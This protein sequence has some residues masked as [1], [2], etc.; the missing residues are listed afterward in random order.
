MGLDIACDVFDAG[1]ELETLEFPCHLAKH[2]DVRI[3]LALKR[4]LVERQALWPVELRGEVEAP[5]VETRVV[6]E[7]Q[8]SFPERGV[9]FAHQLVV[10]GAPHVVD[11]SGQRDR[12]AVEG[13]DAE[14]G[15]QHVGVALAVEV[16]DVRLVGSGVEVE[17][18]LADKA[19]AVEIDR[20]A[21]FAV[22]ANLEALGD[23]K[24]AVP[25]LFACYPLVQHNAA[26]RCQDAEI[27][28]DKVGRAETASYGAAQDPVAPD[29]PTEMQTRSQR[30][31]AEIAAG[32]V[33]KHHLLPL[34][35]RDAVVVAQPQRG[36]E[37]VAVEECELA[38]E[39]G[40]DFAIVE[41]VAVAE[42][43]LRDGAEIGII[44]KPLVDIT[45]AERNAVVDGVSA[46]DF[47]IDQQ[48]DIEVFLLAPI[49]RHTVVCILPEPGGRHLRAKRGGV[50]KAESVLGE[51][52]QTVGGAAEAVDAVAAAHFFFE[53]HI[54]TEA[55]LVD[56]VEQRLRVE[57]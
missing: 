47:G 52:M 39:T 35:G 21:G 2:I 43:V 42:P 28:S 55:I 22:V 16:V 8:Q 24:S 23:V 20:Q 6:A 40:Q 3:G 1:I 33:G 45:V 50:G 19:G 48:V 30:V 10:V 54:A 12:E 51:E 31:A 11:F 38:E 13:F 27:L 57:S 14:I 36:V 46:S 56:V 32:I 53:A 26:S 18:G 49:V 15:L 29:V 5:L 17:D 34:F 44:F 41:V 7:H 25:S 37:A 9:G 4:P